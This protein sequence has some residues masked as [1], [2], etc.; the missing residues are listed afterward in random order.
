MVRWVVKGGFKMLREVVCKYGYN[1]CIAD[2]VR[3]I[4]FNSFALYKNGKF[5]I[6]IN[7]K[8]LQLN[9]YAFHGITIIEI[10]VSFI[11]I[12]VDIITLESKKKEEN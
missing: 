11:D 3:D 7:D 1:T 8:Y 6:N 2:V 12:S 5:I 10:R 9:D 4:P